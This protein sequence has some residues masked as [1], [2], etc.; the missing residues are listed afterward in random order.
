MNR[1]EVESVVLGLRLMYGYGKSLGIPDRTRPITVF[2]DNDLERMVQWY[3]E[4]TGWD[5]ESVRQHWKDGGVGTMGKD[6]IVLMGSPPGE[7]RPRRW[8]YDVAHELV[9][10]AFQGGLEGHLTDPTAFDWNT[11]ITTPRWLMEGMAMLLPEFALPDHLHW[12]HRSGT[13][14]FMENTD[15]TLDEVEV[16]PSG[17]KGRVGPDGKLVEARAIIDCYYR[18]GFLATELLASYVGLNRLVDYFMHLEQWMGPRGVR[19]G[20]LPRPGWR[21]A[22]EK[23]YGMTIDEFYDLFEEHRAAGFPELDIPTPP[24][25]MSGAPGYVMWEI[26]DEVTEDEV[27]HAIK[28]VQLMHDYTV[29]SGMPETSEN[30]TV[31][32]YRNLDALRSA[33]F[34]LTSWSIEACRRYWTKESPVGWGGKGFSLVNVDNPW[35]QDD[36]PYHLSRIVAGEFNNAQKYGL[37]KLRISSAGDAVPEAGPR[38]LDSG[39]TN[40]L[41]TLVGDRAGF[42]AYDEHREWW[43]SRTKRDPMEAPL[44]TMETRVGFEA[45]GRHPYTYSAF[46]AELLVSHAGVSSLLQYYA[47]HQRGTPWQETFENTFGMTIDEFYKL[48]EEHHAAG[49]PEVEL[50]KFVD[51]PTPDPTP[52]PTPAPLTIMPGAPEYVKWQIG[53]DVPSEVA[54]AAAN[55]TRLMHEY[56]VSLGLPEIRQDVEIYLH[57]DLDALTAVNQRL[58]GWSEERSREYWRNGFAMAGS[59]RLPGSWIIIRTSHPSS[60]EPLFLQRLTKISAHELL[61]TYQS[62]FSELRHP[63]RPDDQ[64][65]LTGPRWAREGIAEF[66]AY[67]ASDAGGVLSYDSKRA[68]SVSV[69]KNA[70]PLKDMETHEGGLKGQSYDLPLL[71]AELLASYSGEDALLRFYMFQ[72]PGTTWQVA[73]KVAFGITVDEFY[74][75]FEEHRAAGFPDVYIPTPA[76]TMPG[77]PS[78]VRWEIG[79]EVSEEDVQNAVKAVRLMH[80]YTTSLDMPETYDDIKFHLYSNVDAL[81]S[82]YARVTSW[83]IEDSRHYWRPG[84]GVVYAGEDFAFVNVGHPWIQDNYPYNLLRVVAGELHNA[85]ISRLSELRTDSARDEVPESGPRWLNAGATGVLGPLA[86]S[87]AGVKPYDEHR[88]W[89]V[90]RARNM[91]V[92]LGTMETYAGFVEAGQYEYEYSALAG[93]LLASHAGASALMRYYAN[94]ERGTTWQVVFHE[95]FGM[96]VDEFYELFEEHRAAGFPE[97][98]V[99]KF[100][101]K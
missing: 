97:L 41:V 89:L 21:L 56:V 92:P 83:T 27:Q 75:L 47:N 33:C 7:Q 96:T 26:G 17:Y 93:E 51:K 78:Y 87:E 19:E 48:F 62:E 74:K 13:V 1:S 76:V 12:D 32:L 64:V 15:L 44:S 18:C 29:S 71:A 40:V 69:A 50:P 49:F 14:P 101:D 54:E 80:D 91:D 77:A 2:M 99:P 30:I 73:F 60:A 100:V 5:I 67:R 28:A 8:A 61:H 84:G 58:T 88:E 79:D 4:K 25:T 43:V 95:T 53:A 81:V 24:I 65:P 57:G 34:R 59:V 46:A 22:F 11:N 6:Y 63:G 68:R 38:W 37:S 66:L 98:D 20:D 45:A 55:G 36:Y 86:R 82:A 94:L 70:K 10:T 16:H 3:Q 72:Q 42:R 31:H 39:A 23:A 90:S 9:H 52:T 35:I 85:Q